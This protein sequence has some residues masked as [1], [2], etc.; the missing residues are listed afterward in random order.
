MAE[1]KN[2]APKKGTKG[3][4]KELAKERFVSNGK[5]M[6]ITYP[7]GKKVKT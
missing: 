3:Y 7:N 1:K 4:E 2:N 6:T 5:G